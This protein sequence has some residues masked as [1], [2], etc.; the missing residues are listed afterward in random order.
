MVQDN[1]TK[2]RS[3]TFI[4]PLPEQRHESS[5]VVGGIAQHPVAVNH[6]TSDQT[7]CSCPLTTGSWSSAARCASSSLSVRPNTLIPVQ[8]ALLSPWGTHTRHKTA[9]RIRM[10]NSQWP[11]AAAVRAP[12]ADIFSNIGRV[13]R[14]VNTTL[15]PGSENL[16]PSCDP[17]RP[18]P[19]TA[20]EQ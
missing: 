20:L 17:S 3:A 19:G 16:G 15:R 7:Q 1:N 11:A 2:C 4:A 6:N 9:P 5:W 8:P 14:G 12:L 13:L 10:R 18:E